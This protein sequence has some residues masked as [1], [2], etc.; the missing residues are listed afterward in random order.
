MGQRKTKK[1]KSENYSKDKQ[2]LHLKT[3]ILL[4]LFLA[5]IGFI[6]EKP[7]ITGYLSADPKP[8]CDSGSI[9]DIC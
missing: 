8:I 7:T 4:C 6:I 3:W 2:S 1:Q 9:N 5:L